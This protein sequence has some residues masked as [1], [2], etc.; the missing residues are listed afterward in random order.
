[1]INID[2]FVINNGK[3]LGFNIYGHANYDDFGRD[4]VCSAVSSAAF[5]VANTISQILK[6]NNADICVKKNGEM[7]L[8]IN[9]KEAN[10]C[11]DILSGFKLHMINLEEQYSKNIKVNYVE[12]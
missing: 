12:V 1:M 9:E 2:F 7:Y 5:M 11:N 4:I 6:I 3:L 8:M 10:L